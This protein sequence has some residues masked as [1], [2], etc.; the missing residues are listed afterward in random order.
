M[1]KPRPELHAALVELLG[2]PNVYFQ[3]PESTKLAFPAIVYEREDIRQSYADN[4]VYLRG[5]RYRVTVIDKNPDSEIVERVSML[6]GCRFDRH[7]V[8]DNMNHDVFTLCW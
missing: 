4:L 3:P 7:F 8:A 5:K 2:S 1:A 6:T